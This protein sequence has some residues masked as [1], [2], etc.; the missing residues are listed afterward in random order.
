MAYTSGDN[1]PEFLLLG[2]ILNLI[3]LLCNFKTASL[4]TPSIMP[5]N[6]S[7]IGSVVFEISYVK[8]FQSPFD[9]YSVVNGFNYGGTSHSCDGLSTLRVNSNQIANMF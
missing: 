9:S 6:F 3:R 7:S 5:E 1:H 8:C 2:F 4:W